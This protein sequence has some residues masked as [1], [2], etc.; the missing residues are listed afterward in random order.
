M[1]KTSSIDNKVISSKNYESELLK[2]LGGIISI[3][4]D[5]NTI[6]KKVYK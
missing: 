2:L 4:K 6:Y 3:N 5:S 1:M